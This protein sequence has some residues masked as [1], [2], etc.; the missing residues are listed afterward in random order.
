VIETV[1]FY[2]GRIGSEGE[3]FS[4]PGEE[5]STVFLVVIEKN[6]L[7]SLDT[8]LVGSSENV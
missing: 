8:T 6:T 5:S 7:D 4:L 2:A 1:S 3:R